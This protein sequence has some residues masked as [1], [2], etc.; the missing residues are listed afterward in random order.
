MHPHLPDQ[1]TMQT[2]RAK[3]DSQHRS[4][5]ESYTILGF[6]S[7]GEL[8]VELGCDGKMVTNELLFVTTGTYGRVYMAQLKPPPPGTTHSHRP[9]DLPSLPPTTTVATTT[10]APTTMSNNVSNLSTIIPAQYYAIKKFKPDKEG[11]TITYTGISQSAIR[12]IGLNRELSCARG[13]R[14][15]RRLRRPANGGEEREEERESKKRKLSKDEEVEELHRY[16][17]SRAALCSNLVALK[18][19]ILEDKSIYMV[20]EYAEHDFLVSFLLSS[21]RK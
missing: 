2:Y 13:C 18:E 14:C 4:V 3:R 16:R 10:T 5:L 6:I 19:V 8:G 1:F 11:E 21:C 9:G 17:H 12:E 20:F 7:S 15:V